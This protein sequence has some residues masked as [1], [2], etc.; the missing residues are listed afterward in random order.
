LMCAQISMNAVELIRVSRIAPTCQVRLS[1]HV[2][3]VSYL[4]MM[5]AHAMVWMTVCMIDRLNINLIV[6]VDVFSKDFL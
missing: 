3:M 5:E 4:L 6:F 1:A 2:K